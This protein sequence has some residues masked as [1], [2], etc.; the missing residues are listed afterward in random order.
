V[1]DGIFRIGFVGR[2]RAEKNVSMLADIERELTARGRNSFKFIIVGEGKER[3]D[4]EERMKHAEFPG[5]L[6][7]ADLSRAYAN[8]DLFVF[9]SKTDAFGNVAQEAF[10]SGVPVLVTD[11]GGP[12]FL[13][14]TGKTGFIAKDLDDFV[15]YTI[16]LMDDREELAEMKKNARGS[17]MS[18]SWD[19][20]FE[21]VWDGYRLAY[22]LRNKNFKRK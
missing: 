14:E 22:E 18:K 11:I 4:L 7:G 12:K 1:D 9:P 2:L 8:L 16:R 5:F 3:Q 19:A 15:G 10:A 13:I 6:D 17:A 20:V 21:S